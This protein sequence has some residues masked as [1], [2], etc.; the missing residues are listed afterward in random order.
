MGEVSA[1][2]PA[3][4]R[5]WTVLDPVRA[6]LVAAEPIPD[7]ICPRPRVL[8]DTNESVRTIRAIEEQIADHVPVKE[9]MTHG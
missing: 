1:F 2:R 5:W 8:P 3:Y 4:R 9:T 7:P 6:P